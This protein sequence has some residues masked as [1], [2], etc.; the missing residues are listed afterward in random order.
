MSEAVI[1][2]EGLDEDFYKRKSRRLSR[3]AFISLNG[4]CH[5][6]WILLPFKQD[7]PVEA[8]HPGYLTYSGGS[9]KE[10]DEET[11]KETVAKKGKVFKISWVSIPGRR[12][13]VGRSANNN[14]CLPFDIISKS[15][16]Y[17]KL[18]G[19]VVKY[20]DM[21]SKNGT[22]INERRVKQGIEVAVNSCEKINF[23]KDIEAVLY[24]PA[25]FYDNRII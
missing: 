4:G 19:D 21:G 10:I 6:L 12:I 20:S 9:I 5:L 14:L 18:E 11:R 15:H 13:W 8:K 17:F 25:D 2:L 23:G 3:E 7:D 1:Q 24:L 16:G 22:F